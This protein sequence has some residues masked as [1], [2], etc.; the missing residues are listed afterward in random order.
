MD[1]RYAIQLLKWVLYK[2]YEPISSAQAICQLIEAEYNLGTHAGNVNAVRD[3]LH[4]TSFKAPEV[5]HTN[6]DARCDEYIN[7][8]PRR[9]MTL[10]ADYPDTIIYV[11]LKHPRY[12]RSCAQLDLQNRVSAVG[13]KYYLVTG[14]ADLLHKLQ[15]Q[16]LSDTPQIADTS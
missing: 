8:N 6:P 14:L 5:I 10:K 1:N 2:F 9:G 12:N 13:N 3:Y 7:R 15:L 4:F 16:T 11:E